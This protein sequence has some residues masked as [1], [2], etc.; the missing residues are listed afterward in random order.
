MS[1]LIYLNYYSNIDSKRKYRIAGFDLDWTIIKTKSG[2]IF[3]KDK[4][5]WEIWDPKVLIKLKELS[6]DPDCLIVIISNQKGL[7]IPNKKFL[8]VKEFKEKINNIHKS[9]GINFIFIASLQDDIYRKPRTGSIDFLVD[10][11]QIQLNITKSF[12]VGD[13]AGRPGDKTDSDIKFAKNLG[14]HFLTPEEFF[15]EDKSNSNYKLSGYLL[16]NNSKNTKINIKPENNKMIVISGYP[17]S[18]KSHLANKLTN[19]YGGKS[20]KLFSRDLFQNKFHKKLDESMAQGEPIIVEG[21]YPTNQARQE[22]ITLAEKYHYNTTYIHVKTSYEL[23][24]HLNLYRSLF[25]E[26]NKIPEIVYMKYRKS[27]EYPDDEDWNEIKEYH[28][29]ISGKINKFYLY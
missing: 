25:E 9:L 22:L 13:M 7:G 5:D 1:S 20:F 12:Y 19:E 23:A 29:H 28:P 27:F 15:L 24:Y 21:L 14:V 6:K 3:P 4:S 10:K 8:S 11:E 17:G 2:N 16:D 26:K 18:G